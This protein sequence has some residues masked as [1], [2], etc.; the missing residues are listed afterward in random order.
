[1]AGLPLDSAGGLNCGTLSILAG[2]CGATMAIRSFTASEMSG[3]DHGREVQ[4]FHLTPPFIGESTGAGLN[5]TLCSSEV[6]VVT[7]GGVG[8]RC[9]AQDTH[10]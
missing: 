4:F 5:V 9:L 8:T 7:S 1:M 2:D 3:V 10:R 6:D